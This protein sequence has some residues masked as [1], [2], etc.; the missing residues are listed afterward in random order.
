VIEWLKAQWRAL[1][2]RFIAVDNYEAPEIPAPADAVRA[3]SPADPLPDPLSETVDTP[4]PG[5]VMA[6][7]VRLYERY[8]ESW[9]IDRRIYK[10]ALTDRKGEMSHALDLVD[11]EAMIAGW[12]DS[13]IEVRHGHVSN[14]AFNATQN[15]RIVKAIHAEFVKRFEAV[16]APP[17]PV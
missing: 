7:L 11:I 1:T 12:A 10:R 5:S 13:T 16:I 8:G 14:L 3:D 4:F 9:E 2:D 15:Q 17:G 6:D